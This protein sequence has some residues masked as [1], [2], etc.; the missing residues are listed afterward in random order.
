MSTT[1]LAGGS[2]LPNRMPVDI[3]LDWASPGA[4][5]GITPVPV[6]AHLHGGDSQYLSDGLPDAW[7]TP[8]AGPTPAAGCTNGP[9]PQEGRL[10]SFPY[11]YD[12]SQEAGTLWYHDHALG[13]T[14][15]NVYMGLAGFYVL[16]DPNENALRAA[17][18]LPSFPYE[19]PIVIQDR[20]FDSAG[21]L[22]YPTGKVPVN[23][24]LP[25]FF[26]RLALV[27][28]Q[29]WPKLNVEQRKYR[30]R[31]LNGSDSRFYDLRFEVF[32]KNAQITPGKGTPVPILVIG[33]ELGLLD[34]PAVPD[35]E[36]PGGR[37]AAE[38]PKRAGDRPRRTLRRN[39]GLHGVPPAVAWWSPTRPCR[40]TRMPPGRPT[41]CWTASWPSMSP[42]RYVGAQC[43][44]GPGY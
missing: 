26:G 31:L 32:A 11:Q 2:P 17:G 43:D 44:G 27:N 8:C 39:R 5:G 36:Y 20:E 13:I 22:V 34:T 14:R 23:S 33:D 3:T 38:H 10:F 21:Q 9:E 4:V 37:R 1:W 24:V 29:A 16:H 18:V 19:V 42:C 6:V 30:L 40:R 7:G 35:P 28:G 41:S 12:N 25:E 15:T